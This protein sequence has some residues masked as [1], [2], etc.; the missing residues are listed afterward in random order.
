MFESRRGHHFMKKIVIVIILLVAVLVAGGIN[1]FSRKAPD[2]LRRTIERSLKK[3]VTIQSIQ[4]R[5]PGR[6]KLSGVEVRDQEGVFKGELCFAV[7]KI[8]LAVSPLSFFRGDLVIQNFDVENALVTVRKHQGRFYHVLSDASAS[9]PASENA[10]PAQGSPAK[11]S[12]PPLTIRQFRLA[13]GKFQFVDYDVSPGGFVIAL[14]R[15]QAQINHIHLPYKKAKTY[16]K[17]Q[18]LMPQ[19]REQKPASLEANGWTEF[20]DYDTEALLV[21]QGLY[22]PYF[23]PYLAQITP[24]SIREG[25]LNDRL[26]VRVQNKLLNATADLEATGLYF[27]TYEGGDEL[28]GLKADEILSFLKDASGRLKFQMVVEWNVA[29]KSVSRKDIIRRSIE[30]SLKKTVVGNLGNFLENT[31]RRIGDKG[32]DGSGDDLKDALKKVKELFG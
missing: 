7:D 6:F 19:G 18:A 32:L 5:F 13:E 9:P 25:Y 1:I 4:Y 3:S 22:L 24:A 21:T 26:S 10:A 8:D 30:Q 14:D 12:N 2:F 31:L 23:Q 20:L 29:D 28:F 27:Q 15:I 17:L 11:A 16:Y